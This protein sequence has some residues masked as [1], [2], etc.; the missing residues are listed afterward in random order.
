MSQVKKL[1]GAAFLLMVVTFLGKIAGFLREVFI[2]AEF[3]TSHNADIFVAVST[4]PN[5]LLTI[6]GGA[7]SAA[8]IP[9]VVRLCN[10]KE[11]IRLKRLISSMF[12]ITGLSMMGLALLLF[13][14]G[15]EFTGLYVVGFSEEAKQ[16]TLQ[17]IRIILPALVA[18]GLISLFSSILNAYQH[19]FIPS[20]GPVFYSLGVIIATV[21][22]ASTYG[23]KSLIIGMAIGIFV[24]LFLVITVTIKKG[25]PFFPSRIW[26]NEDIRQVGKLMLPIFIGIGAFQ[27][28]ILVDRMMASTL[29]EGSLAALN[30]AYRV[31]Q[32]PL[33]LFVGSMVLPLYPM[34]ADKIANQDMDGAKELLARSYHLLGILLLPVI[35]VFVALAEPVIAILFQRGQFDA[36]AVKLTSLALIL[37]SFTILPFAMRDVITRA[38]YALQDTWTPVINSVLLIALNITL[39]V[40]FVPKLGMIAI[41]GSTS[42]SFIFAYFRLRYKLIRKIGKTGGK[43]EQKLWFK[44]WRNAFVF[45][46]ITWGSY[47]GLMFIWS[48]P[49]GMELWLRTLVSLAIGG[50]VYLYLTFQIN[51]PEVDWLK[52]RLQQLLGRK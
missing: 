5:L 43:E 23:V 1:L 26:W 31:T 52:T 4:I 10:Q 7:L 27:L 17:M 16:L 25:I 32:L 40:I 51:T 34:I 14:F 11:T 44:I 41:A 21:F 29:P 35:G 28:N 19:F 18:I 46:I 33:S 15:E 12:S 38:M 13:F 22:F 8:L 36:G 24:Q 9:M 49:I 48:K 37:Y 42:I 3:G 6:T 30:Y 2:A 45:T 47:H 39:M 50:F 20:L